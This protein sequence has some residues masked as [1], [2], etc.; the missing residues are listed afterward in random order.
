[1]ASGDAFRQVH[2]GDPLRFPAEVFNQILDML[3]WY[4]AQQLP[5]GGAQPQAGGRVLVKNTTGSAVARGSVLKVNGSLLTAT[6]NVDAWRER[7]ALTGTTPDGSG[8]HCVTLE[9]IPAG[10]VGAAAIS[11]HAQVV[12]NVTDAT[13][14]YAGATSGDAT[15]LTSGTSGEFTIVQKPSGTGDKY[16]TVRFGGVASATA[17]DAPA[18]PGWWGYLDRDTLVV[19]SGTATTIEWTSETLGRNDSVDPFTPP[20][21]DLDD[22]GT[23][24]GGDAQGYDF[25]TLDI[26]WEGNATGQRHVEVCPLTDPATTAFSKSFRRASTVGTSMDTW[27]HLSWFS[28]PFNGSPS[29][30]G[31]WVINVYQDSGSD[32]NLYFGAFDHGFGAGLNVYRTW[33]HPDYAP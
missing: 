28:N 22:D 23:V 13:H 7:P 33:W 30:M 27:Q 9:G 15:K 5:A 11:G 25:W 14:A 26:A 29:G 24:L 32:L 3:R 12:V 19:P 17:T 1:M 4:K 18:V 21:W 8:T 10:E 31:T 20:W 2:E 6:A 16:C